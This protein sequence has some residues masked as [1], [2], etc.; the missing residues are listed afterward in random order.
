MSAI[1]KSIFLP[2]NSTEL[3][4][5]ITAQDINAAVMANAGPKI[6]NPLLACKGIISSFMINFNPSAK[7]C[8]NPKGPALSGPGLSCKIAATF[9]S[10]NVVYKAMPK[11]ASTIIAISTSFSISNK[12]SICNTVII[13]LN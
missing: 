13:Q 8:N 1:C 11:L 7:G 2:N 5:G 6:N 3:L 10:A 12:I 4:Q 9:L